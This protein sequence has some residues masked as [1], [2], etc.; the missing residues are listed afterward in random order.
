LAAPMIYYL[1]GERDLRSVLDFLEGPGQALAKRVK[2]VAYEDLLRLRKTRPPR[3]AYIF[4]LVSSRQRARETFTRLY[5]YV[6]ERNGPERVLNDPAKCLRRL[7]LLRALHRSGINPFDAWRASDPAGPQGWPVFLRREGGTLWRQV[8]LLRDRE[9]YAA[10]LKR[11]PEPQ[12]MVAIQW[13]DTVGPG[14]IYRKYGAFVVG[15]QIVPRHVFFSPNWLVKK[16]DIVG[17]A[18]VA[19]E[20]AYLESNPHAEAL[21][22]VCRVGNIAYGRIDYAVQNGRPVIWE[23]NL[24]PQIM[25]QVS[26]EYPQ[27]QAAHQRFIALFARALDA[28]DS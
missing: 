13:H 14:G 27:R 18:Q 28:L 21:R 24:V 11:A 16:P 15:K 4:T 8:P 12:K 26:A 17:E 19:E 20:L 22:E 3:G 1:T 10:E 25:G 9:A 23:I 6:L 5:R 7:E 2:V